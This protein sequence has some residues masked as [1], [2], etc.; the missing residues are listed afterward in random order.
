MWAM[1]LYTGSLEG[2]GARCTQRHPEYYHIRCHLHK[3]H[4]GMH[5]HEVNNHEYI[6]WPM[7]EGHLDHPEWF[8]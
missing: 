5:L 4:E 2:S 1:D 8:F 3:W 7:P 6:G